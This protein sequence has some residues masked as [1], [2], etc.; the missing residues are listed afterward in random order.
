[1]PPAR[2]RAYTRTGSPSLKIGHLVGCEAWG[3]DRPADL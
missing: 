2:F 3:R 1:V